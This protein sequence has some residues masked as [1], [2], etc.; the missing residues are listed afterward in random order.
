MEE[1]DLSSCSFSS[2]H[3][4][5]SSTGSNKVQGQQADAEINHLKEVNKQLQG[6]IE[7]LKQQLNSAMEATESINGMNET[8]SQLKAQLE[9][10]KE[11][12][13]KL[14]KELKNIQA[15]NEEQVNKLNEDIEA[16]EQKNQET[17]NNLN[18]EKERSLKLKKE[19]QSLKAEID[20]KSTMIE[21]IAIELKEA[22][23]SKKKLRT[24]FIETAEK[25]Q[26]KDEENQRLSLCIQ[27]DENTK[28]SLTQEIDSLRVKLSQEMVVTEECKNTINKLQKDLEQKTS[29]IATFE[30]QLDAQRAEMEEMSQE[31]HN[32]ILLIQKMHA[33]FTASEQKVEDISKE[34]A[35]LKLKLQKAGKNTKISSAY[36]VSALTLPFEGDIGEKAEHISKLPQYQPVQRMQLIINE[37]ARTIKELE[38]TSQTRG[39]EIKTLKNQL[40]QA[41]AGQTPYCQILDSLLKELKNISCQEAQINNAN[42]CRIDT[43]FIEFMAE[44]SAEIEPL[45]KD[46]LLKDPRFIPSD[47]FTTQDVAKKNECIKE[48]I[49]CSDISYSIF[50][51]QFLTN[52]L[53]SNQLQALMG[54]LGKMEEIS[55]LDVV[56]GDFND[57]PNLLQKLQDKIRSLKKTRSQLHALLKQQTEVA[58]KSLKSESELKTTVSQL[59]I[60]NDSLKS[61][62][63]VLKVKYQVASNELLLKK[64]EENLNAFASQIRETVDEQQSETKQRTDRLE[65]ELQQ[66]TLENADLTSLIKKL[67]TSIDVSTK[68]QNKRFQKQEDALKEQIAE[69]EQQI[70]L[71]QD[72]LASKKKNAKRTERSLREQYDE[73]INDVTNHYEESKRSLQKSVDDLKIKAAEAR[74][75]TKKLQQT[76]TETETKNAKLTEDNEA[77][78]N[79]KKALNAQLTAIKQQISKDK[80]NLQVQLAAQMMACES[81]IRS[82]TQEVKA[83]GEKH[84]KDLFSLIAET[85]GAFYGFDDSDFNDESLKQ[86]LAHAKEDLIRLQ[87]FQ[88]EATKL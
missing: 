5:N 82:A 79:E 33:A 49:N 51:A 80:Q 22:K 38:E 17:E 24:K 64:N 48:I 3:D 68:K 16:L 44:K 75:M 71:L 14:N 70:E 41:L 37:A 53:L 42:L 32:I 60:T 62:I 76:V 15:T 65:A 8:I 50:T 74:D 19:K 6:S 81:K 45:I 85:F 35:T 4:E 36:D 59:Q 86:V 27:D 43:A 13:I 57:I 29:L 21:N 28:N 78:Q 73:A 69:M 9:E 7:S 26:I 34:N 39:D 1:L 20:E 11:R 55:R 72:E 61:E 63:D 54:P 77:L 23:T 2:E 52:Q 83:E 25:L 31:R 66:K 30:E 58:N 67:Q 40:D 47:F 46:N 88:N 84:L 18:A 87:Y 56:G 10:S 12:E